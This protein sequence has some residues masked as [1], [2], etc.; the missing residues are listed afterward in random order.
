MTISKREKEVLHLIAREHSA[1]EIAN[2]LYLSIHTVVSHRKNLLKKLKVR[3]A[4]GMVRRGFEL[5][6]LSY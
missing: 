5:G 4:A 6:Y 2:L 3:N 1:P